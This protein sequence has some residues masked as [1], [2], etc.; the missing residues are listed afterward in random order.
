ML[1]ESLDL[2]KRL[3]GFH[4]QC[5]RR[6]LMS[7]LYASCAEC[8]GCTTRQLSWQRYTLHAVLSCTQPAPAMQM[9]LELLDE[10]DSWHKHEVPEEVSAVVFV[11]NQSYAGGNDLWQHDK[12]VRSG[13]D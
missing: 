4:Q 7:L 5:T 10:T 12:K 1:Y 8:T 13:D 2:S 6:H 11:N 3:A 9:D